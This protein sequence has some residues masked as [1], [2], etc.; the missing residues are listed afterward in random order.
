MGYAVE[1]AAF[2]GQKLELVQ[3]P[4]I[5]AELDVP[6]IRVFGAPLK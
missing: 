2:G 1:K 4:L 6:A 3:P 5:M